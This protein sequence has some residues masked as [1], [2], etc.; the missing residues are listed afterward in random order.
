MQQPYLNPEGLF[1]LY[2]QDYERLQESEGCRGQQVHH[3]HDVEA[4]GNLVATVTS[5]GYVANND[6]R[7]PSEVSL[8]E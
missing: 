4:D 8:F 2:H 6:V 7:P 1:S 5:L 3:L